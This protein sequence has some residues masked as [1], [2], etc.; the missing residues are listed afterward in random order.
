MCGCPAVKDS[1]WEVLQV[2][3]LTFSQRQRKPWLVFPTILQLSF[4]MYSFAQSFDRH[5]SSYHPVASFGGSILPFEL[6]LVMA[7][8]I[9]NP[10]TVQ[11]PFLKCTP[12]W[13]QYSQSWAANTTISSHL[14][15]P[16]DFNHFFSADV[17][18][19]SIYLVRDMLDFS[20]TMSPY[21]WWHNWTI[22]L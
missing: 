11:L 21:L 12:Q 7:L 6:F 8:L 5:W 13:F 9:F 2:V 18:A 19:S 15:L 4:A 3:E 1:H 20:V 22:K 14:I 10:H 16:F 17:L